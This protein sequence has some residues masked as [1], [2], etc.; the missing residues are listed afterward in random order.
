M[1]LRVVGI[2]GE[3][4]KIGYKGNSIKKDSGKK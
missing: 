1:K 2:A 3:E 4:T